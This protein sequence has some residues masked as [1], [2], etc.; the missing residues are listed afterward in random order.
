MEASESFNQRSSQDEPDEPRTEDSELTEEE[1]IIREMDRDI[2]NECRRRNV[3]S[4][5]SDQQPST[6]ASSSVN[7]NSLCKEEDKISIKL[8]YLN[9]EIKTVYA[10]LNET[11]GMF[12]R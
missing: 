12:K 5:S 3:A 11:I 2:P 6:S 9:D 1:Q 10:Y 4:A 8:K 7:E